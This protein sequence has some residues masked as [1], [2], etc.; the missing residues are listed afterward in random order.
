MISPPPIKAFAVKDLRV[1]R[2]VELLC[3]EDERPFRMRVSWASQ[4]NKFAQLGS[5]YK[6]KITAK[7]PGGGGVFVDIGLEHKVYLRKTPALT[8]GETAIVKV[9]AEARAEKSAAVV[10]ASISREKA[11]STTG[12]VI[13]NPDADYFY[14]GVN[15]QASPHDIDA[16]EL[17]DEAMESVRSES[18]KLPLGGTVHIEPTK[19]FVAIDVDSEGRHTRGDRSHFALTINHEAS[20]VVARALALKSLGGLVVIDFLKMSRKDEQSQ[21]SSAFVERVKYYSSQKV[22]MGSMSKFGLLEASLS[23]G[24]APIQDQLNRVTAEERL[25]LDA[26]DRLVKMG[27]DDRGARLCLKVG[28]EINKWLVGNES[29]WKEQV[30]NEIGPRFEVALNE[31]ILLGNEEVEFIS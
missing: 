31:G 27:R 7:D 30:Q 16:S 23:H 11:N 18:W 5:V 24:A 13:S 25:A 14:S 17:V 20:D 15:L 29:C 1:G 22:E 12:G 8:V 3:T 6:G 10:L 4:A 9:V 2:T 28:R 19:A 21:L 26:L